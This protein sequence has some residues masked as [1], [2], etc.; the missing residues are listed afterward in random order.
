MYREAGV[1]RMYILTR[2]AQFTI[3]E[4]GL[5]SKSR[6]SSVQEQGY[7]YVQ[8]YAWKLFVSGIWQEGVVL[9]A[10]PAKR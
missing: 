3:V 1:H 5:K 6:A 9:V 2:N 7:K 10:T 4:R 8:V